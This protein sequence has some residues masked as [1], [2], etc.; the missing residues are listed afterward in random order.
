MF[1][2]TEDGED[3]LHLLALATDGHWY[4]TS[5]MEYSPQNKKG[6]LISVTTTVIPDK[7]VFLSFYCKR[8]VVLAVD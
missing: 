4:V 1:M 8:V 6:D 2:F 5:Q 7:L 3:A